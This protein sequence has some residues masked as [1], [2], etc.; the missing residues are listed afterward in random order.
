MNVR[1]RFEHDRKVIDREL[2]RILQVGPDVP[3]RLAQAMRY[4]VFGPGKRLRPILALESYRAAGGR[5]RKWIMPF[6]CGIELIH[7]FSLIH[8]DL[9]SMDNDDFRRGRPSLHI[10]FD[11]ATAILAADGL[12]ILAFE[13]FC[14]STAPFERRTSAILTICEAVG[15]AG[16]VAGQ[17]LDMGIEPK[18]GVRSLMRMQ[19]KKT[20]LFIAAALVSG[21]I[22][23][24]APRPVLS[25]LR[26]AGI[27]LGEM[28]QTTDDLLD[29]RQESD[30]RKETIVSRFGPE[31]ALVRARAQAEVAR[32]KLLSLGPS[33]RFLAELTQIILL[34]NS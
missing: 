31:R 17:M 21:A 2:G 12:L 8:D 19:R 20:A 23:A 24:G 5:S 33:Y 11:E 9:P 34:R 4:A 22:I 18:M 30:Q 16:M 7:T 10:R 25:R 3:K 14:R 27:A 29:I 28:F 15:P 6:C 13:L 32:T 26:Q 1:L